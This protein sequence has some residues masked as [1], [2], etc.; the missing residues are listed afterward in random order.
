MELKDILIHMDSTPQC[1]ARLD[2]AIDLARRRQAHLT[3]LY[4]IAHR[5]Y[6]P[7]HG[8]VERKISDAQGIF[9]QLT[10]R[11]G[12]SSA[13]LCVDSGVTGVSMT[14]IVSDHAQLT[15]LIIVGQHD[16]ASPDATLPADL[17]E[18]LVLGSGRPVLVVPYAGIFKTVGERVM[19][20]WKG[21]RESV[22]AVNDA[23]PFMKHA[24]QVAVLTVGPTERHQ[25]TGERLCAHLAR[26]GIMAKA[27][28]VLSAGL[29]IGDVLLNQTAVE[30]IDLLVIGGYAFSHRG[31]LALG[32]V[33]RHLLKYMTVPV[34]LSH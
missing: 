26:H 2:L 24:R 7:Q 23:I 17:P 34:L 33:A 25:N 8:D 10:A 20:A 4:V 1:A 15:D 9:S 30:G 5:F 16:P 18:R 13:W 21:G 22:R 3:G 29:P 32:D 12:V 28:R 14:E 6:E 31:K 11:A 27:E 19:V